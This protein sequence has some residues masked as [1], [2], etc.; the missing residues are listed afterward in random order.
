MNV[1]LSG[2]HPSLCLASAVNQTESI[3]KWAPFLRLVLFE[4]AKQEDGAKLSPT[5]ITAILENEVHLL[6]HLL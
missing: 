5:L 6:M 2:V 1:F 3:Q 4:V